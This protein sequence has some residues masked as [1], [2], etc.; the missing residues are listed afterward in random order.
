MTEII[1]VGMLGIVTVL[2]AIQFKAQKPE[3]ST[4]IGLAVGVLVF[5]YVVRQI[6]A[7][8]SQLNFIQSYLGEA[9]EYLTILLKVIGITY[10]CEF[11]AGICK[12]A[13]YHSISD[14]IEILGKL[15]VMFAG[16]PIL[17][18]VIEQIQSVM[19]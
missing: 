6:E 9:K 13:G 7:V 12:D 14:Q 18:A 1:K 8:M 11:S 5:C 17:F 19:A 16:L 2:I 3:Y 10:I 4:Y 15:S